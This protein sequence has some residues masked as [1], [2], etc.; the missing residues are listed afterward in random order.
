MNNSNWLDLM[1]RL[2][3]DSNIDTYEK[4]ESC[5][6]EKHRYYHN[7]N[8]INVTLKYLE[9]VHD[10]ADNY[11]AVEL[12]LWFHDA[13]Y[14]IFSS[15]NELDS[16]NWASEFLKSN[17]A[18]D[19]LIK[20]VHRL[21]MSTLHTITPTENDQRL[22]VDIDLTILGCDTELYDEFELWIRKEYQLI[23]NVI[24]RKKRKEVLEGFLAK[25]RIYSHQYFINLFEKSARKNLKSAIESL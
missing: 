14:N 8:H 17:N 2:G 23:P 20:I 21:I 3:F 10:L 25:E 7:S 5:Y 4:L 6:S 12:A 15:T 18:N 19:E 1:K 22:I 24:Y 13:I 11:N 16:A 9:Q